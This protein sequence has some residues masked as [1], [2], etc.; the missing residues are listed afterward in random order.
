MQTIIHVNI[1]PE[2]RAAFERVNTTSVRRE[3][4]W[5]V[6]EVLSS[7]QDLSKVKDSE[8][9]PFVKQHLNI[10]ESLHDALKSAA[11]SL[12][13]SVSGIVRRCLSVHL[14]KQLD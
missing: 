5:A 14:V 1:T 13:T 3:I 2:Q 7:K 11:G 10:P 8:I 12:G 9:G 4:A 6:H